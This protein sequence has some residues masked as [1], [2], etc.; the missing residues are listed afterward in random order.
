MSFKNIYKTISDKILQMKLFDAFSI[1]INLQ[2]VYLDRCVKGQ[3]KL[4]LLKTH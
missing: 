4:T 1:I 2:N 3:R